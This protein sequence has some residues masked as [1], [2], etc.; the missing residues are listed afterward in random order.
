MHRWLLCWKELV[1]STFCFFK[2]N[3]VTLV[4]VICHGRC[5]FLLNDGRVV[6]DLP[7]LEYKRNVKKQKEEDFQSFY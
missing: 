2:Y 7:C 6:R 4:L 5:L 3:F 1:I